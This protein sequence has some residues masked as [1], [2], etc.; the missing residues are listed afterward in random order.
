MK[1]T[2]DYISWMDDP[3]GG[4]YISNAWDF[5]TNKEMGVGRM[6]LTERQRIVSSYILTQ[7]EDGRFPYTT[8]IISDIKK[9]G[10][11]CWSASIAAWF[12]ECAPPYTD[13][14][15][16]A[17][18][19]EQSERLIF[20]DLEFHYKHTKRGKPLKDKIEMENGS[21]LH[22]FS[23]SYTAAAGSRHA[24]TIW[25]EL[26][27][28]RTKD[29]WRRWDELQPV[30][31]VPHSLRLVSSYAG[32]YGE[33]ELLY[34][35]YTRGVD[36]EETNTGKGT[37]LKELD[38]LPCYEN[39]AQFT[40]WNHTPHMPWQSEKY[41][42]DARESER[43]NA[44]LRLHENRWVTSRETFIPI[45]WWE[46]AEEH[47]QQSAV[48]WKEHPYYSA[49]VYVAVDA[50]SKRD[51]TAVV[52]VAVDSLKG[53][54]AILFHK[55]WTPVEKD[56]ILNLEQTLEPF[57]L[58]MSKQFRFKD[59]ACDPNHMYQII[60]RLRNKGLP[61]SEFSQVDSSMTQASQTLYDL[62]RQDNILAYPAPDIKEHLRNVMA[63]YTN[64]GIRMIKDKSNRRAANK[65]V[66][67][68]IALA[69]ACH[70]AYEGVG[71]EAGT[72]IV[73]AS[74]IPRMSGWAKVDT[75]PAWMP[76][77]FRT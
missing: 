32:F 6:Q 17:N 14:V 76:F 33:S 2:Q 54:I 53:K 3:D 23:K 12:L 45:E 67:A 16:C 40:Y 46:A 1:F 52:G 72:P 57:L 75:D 66:D 19:M 26:W 58:K 50:S 21:K 41:Y 4:F 71:I 9:S 74:D 10:K 60:I 47:L 24:L 64:R 22:I 55:I 29:D 63:E 61:V 48:M 56:K 7:D 44:Y 73:I 65:K 70:R 38:P 43:P 49:P 5:D 62:L 25:D 37:L 35:L 36:E 13:I 18:S 39:N 69:M 34:D 42:Q 77:P 8:A 51:C 11:T 31:T 68:A 15:L 30:P 59:V 27:G 28:A 20:S